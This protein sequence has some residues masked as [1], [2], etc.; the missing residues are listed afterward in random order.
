MATREEV[1]EEGYRYYCI[2]CSKVFK[3]LPK[4]QYEDGHGGRALAMCRCGSDL[5]ANLKDDSRVEE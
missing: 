5:F 1:I 4:E 3:E 2:A